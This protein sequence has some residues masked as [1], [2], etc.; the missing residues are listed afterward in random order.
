MDHPRERG[1][2]LPGLGAGVLRGPPPRA[3][4]KHYLTCGFLLLSAV[5]HSAS[6]E[7]FGLLGN[8]AA[9]F[10]RNVRQLLAYSTISQVGYLLVV[11]TVAAGSDMALP[12]LLLYLSAYAVTNLGAFA[13]VCP[14]PKRSSS[15]TTGACSADVPGWRSAWQRACLL[16]L[17]G[18]PPTAVFAGKLTVFTAAF[19][20][21]YAWLVVV[22]AINTV[23]SL[24]Y[25]V[26]WIAP[27]IRSA[28]APAAT[29]LD[30][31]SARTAYVATVASLALGPLAGPVVAAFHG[32][33]TV[34]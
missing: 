28:D 10:Q 19:D 31:W 13:V 14:L 16:G 6:H 26:R 24:F 1:K 18:T 15:T 30:R 32:G 22:A 29:E 17:V 23:A 25:Y 3:R 34:L 2:H 27:A 33:L 7:L 11:V 12:S 8:L 4:G 9:F 21:G 5:P 20:G